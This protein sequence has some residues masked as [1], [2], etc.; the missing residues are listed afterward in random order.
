MYN[1]AAK[2]M[3]NNSLS[4]SMLDRAINSHLEMKQDG[5][6]KKK[7]IFIEWLRLEGIL[8]LI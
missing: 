2:K 5:I 1:C 3:V 7:S 4:L 8:K 6:K